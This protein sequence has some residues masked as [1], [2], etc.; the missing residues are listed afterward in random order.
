VEVAPT[1]DTVG[2]DGSF[3]ARLRDVEDHHFWFR[4]RNRLI[5]WA[6]DTYFPRARTFLDAGAGTGQVARAIHRRRA[7]LAC[8]LVEA[9]DA[10]LEIAAE[11]TAPVE[12]VRADVHHLPWQDE[13]DV[14]AAFDVVEHVEDDVGV[15]RQLAQAAR[16]GGGV[17]ITVPQHAWLWSPVDDFSGHVRRYT[18]ARLTDT[19]RSAGLLV[20]RI[21]SFTTLLLPVLMASRWARRGRPVDP[22]AEF[23][24]SAAAN[25]VGGVAMQLDRAL[26][27]AG[28]S[29]PAGGSLLAIA[30]RPR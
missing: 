4:E 19:M 7:D 28:L 5:L 26:I 20:E 23:R 22:M 21:T 18:R 15:I 10:G 16:P 14:V 2:F 9:F 1:P 8:T 11:G 3:F 25:I 30:R 29:L 12:L 24:T 27:A 6:L 17:I 13:F